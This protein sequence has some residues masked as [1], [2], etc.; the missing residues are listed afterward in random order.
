MTIFI[1]ALSTSVDIEESALGVSQ[2]FQLL[3]LEILKLPYL[4]FIK[5]NILAFELDPASVSCVLEAV[6][7]VVM[8][9]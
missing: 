2:P 1:A 4:L 7:L 8:K 6:T 3:C 9:M 5:I